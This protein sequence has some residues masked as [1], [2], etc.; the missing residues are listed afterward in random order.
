MKRMF[1][2]LIVAGLFLLAAFRAEAWDYVY[3]SRPAPST[4][5]AFLE[6]NKY[7]FGA[8]YGN[9]P[10]FFSNEARSRYFYTAEEKGHYVLG[11]AR[12]PL[13]WLPDIK[14]TQESDPL[15][16]TGVL[17]TGPAKEGKLVPAHEAAAQAERALE[18]A[19][20]KE[21]VPR[22]NDSRDIFRLIEEHKWTIPDFSR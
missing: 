5:Q 7:K 17:I 21:P 4:Y 16:E 12:K 2:T 8:I 3:H 1:T 15:I 10:Y 18:M 14:I 9:Y 20:S 13:P 6:S 19:L 22:I 11:K